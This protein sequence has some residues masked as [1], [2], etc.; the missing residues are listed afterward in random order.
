MRAGSIACHQSPECCN[1]GHER[2]AA[3]S[4]RNPYHPDSGWVPHR[5]QAV[6]NGS[7]LGWRAARVNLDG[8]ARMQLDPSGKVTTS[9]GAVRLFFDGTQ[10]PLIAVA[11]GQVAAV[12]P[13]MSTARKR[14]RSDWNTRALL[15]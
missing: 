5:D 3:A 6:A 7:E 10:A 9:I 2:R 8:A 1:N 4:H 15:P 12:V 13:S 11:S 14:C